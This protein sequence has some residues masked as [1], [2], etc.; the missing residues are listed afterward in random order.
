L[1]N[2]YHLIDALSDL[3]DKDDIIAPGMSSNCVVHTFQAWRVKYGQRFTCACA[4]GAMGTGIPA[5]IGARLAS[6]R[7]RTITLNGDGG[8][9]LNIQELEVVARLVLPIKFFVLSNGG[10]QA[11]M[12]TQRKYFD[13]R[14]VGSASPDYTLPD[15][16]AVAEAYGIKT[17]LI[18]NEDDIIPVC[19]QVL[20]DTLPC[21]VEVI[22]SDEQVTVMRVD[23]KLVNGK[24]VS[25]KFEDV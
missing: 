17:L 11:I 25:G 16:R 2:N 8:F 6:G 9:Q 20:S 23:T 22:E 5:A 21:V 4:M 15:I 12:N 13:G 14:L 24:P 19:K 3:C 10:Y 7:K 18:E 1:I